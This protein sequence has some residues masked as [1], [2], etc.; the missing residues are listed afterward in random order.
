MPTLKK[1]RLATDLITDEHFVGECEAIDALAILDLGFKLFFIKD[2]ITFNNQI[3]EFQNTYHHSYLETLNKIK[4]RYAAINEDIKTISPK[5][6]YDR[7]LACFDKAPARIIVNG[8]Y[9]W[10][11]KGYIYEV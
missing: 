7:Y 1:V 11:F 6:V 5:A 9:Q 8:K 4:K 3:K 2:R 10:V